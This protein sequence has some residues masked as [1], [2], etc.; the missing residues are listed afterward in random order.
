MGE[1]GEMGGADVAAVAAVVAATFEMGE[2]EMVLMLLLLLLLQ[3]LALQPHCIVIVFSLNKK[4]VSAY[5]G[6]TTRTSI[7]SC[8]LSHLLLSPLPSLS[9]AWYELLLSLSMRSGS[10]CA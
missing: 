10:R 3:L 2:V 5:L 6:C 8:L 9:R 4:V 7:R 1:V